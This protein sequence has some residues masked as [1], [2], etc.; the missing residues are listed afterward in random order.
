M[1]WT[2]ERTERNKG[3]IDELERAI[4]LAASKDILMFC[5]AT[6]QGAY[7]D[8][9]YPAASGTKKIFKIGA[10]EASG[11]AYKWV[12]DQSAVD[13]I[14]PGHQ[15]V[16]E[17]HDDRNVTKFTPLTGS[18]VATALASGLAAIVLYCVQLG[19]VV[20]AD[21]NQKAETQELQRYEALKK[22]ERMKD[23][24]QRIGLDKTSE[25]KYILV[26]NRF[27]LKKNSTLKKTEKEAKDQWIFLMPELADDLMREE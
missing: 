3:D 15:V 19:G 6:D 18:S 12:G 8:R 16:L 5:A 20:R 1:S 2:I 27:G 9:T 10:A 21:G 13:F 25:H 7:R 26:W 22:H 11:A 4:E 24:L 14:M 17:R 23:A